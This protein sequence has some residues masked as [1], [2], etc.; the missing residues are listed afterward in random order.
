MIHR[1][2]AWHI[3]LMDARWLKL[4]FDMN[5]AKSKA[6]LARALGLEPSAVSKIL[7]S[8]RQIKARE[9]YCMRR[10]FGL[11]TDGEKVLVAPAVSSALAARSLNNADG[12]Q[13]GF[14]SGGDWVIPADVLSG[15]AGP[16]PDKVRIFH[17]S[18]GMMEPDYRRGEGVLADLSEQHPSPP[19]VF[20][21]S[22]GFGYMLRR[23]ELVPRASPEKVRISATSASF[24]TQILDIND[25]RIVGRVIARLQWV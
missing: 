17:V 24:Q 5:P 14:Q 7:S 19:G 12:L 25:F 18:D 15:G 11:P 22:D 2:P 6:D 4:Q 21:V 20:I 10:F 23:C 9:Y 16:S 13:E 8:S 3:L 1:Q